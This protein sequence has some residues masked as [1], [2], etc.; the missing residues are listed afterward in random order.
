MSCSRCLGLR[1][2]LLELLE[3]LW[4]LRRVHCLPVERRSS[5]RLELLAHRTS[6]IASFRSELFL[7][8]SLIASIS[9]RAMLIQNSAM[10]SG[11]SGTGGSGPSGT[12]GSETRGS[13]SMAPRPVDSALIASRGASGWLC[14]RYARMP[15]AVPNRTV[16]GVMMLRMTRL[17][18]KPRARL[19]ALKYIGKIS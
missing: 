19:L 16:K 8:S 11:P 10:P 2:V 1:H 4:R 18:G 3:L 14:R 6:M 12:G 9:S 17:D 15:S 13:S 7:C 5:H